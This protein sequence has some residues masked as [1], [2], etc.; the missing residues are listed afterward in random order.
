MEFNVPFQHKYGYHR[1]HT[2]QT[3]Q[4]DDGWLRGWFIPFV[5]KRVSGW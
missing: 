5:D 2:G 3:T 1:G 4:C